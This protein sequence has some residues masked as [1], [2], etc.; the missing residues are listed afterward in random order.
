MLLSLSKTYHAETAVEPA[1]CSLQACLWFLKEKH[2]KSHPTIL[3]GK[4]YVDKMG[5]A[6]QAH[7]NCTRLA[8]KFR[9]A[10]EVVA[11]QCM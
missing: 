8:T 4:L 11:S 9:H 2:A 10:E 5:V 3:L 6:A 7:A 1:G